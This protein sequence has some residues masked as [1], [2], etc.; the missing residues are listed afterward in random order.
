MGWQGKRKG[1]FY[2]TYDFPLSIP[3]TRGGRT[4][5]FCRS[6]FISFPLSLSLSIYLLTRVYP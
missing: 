4:L 1:D 6:R 5:F 3:F 2:Q